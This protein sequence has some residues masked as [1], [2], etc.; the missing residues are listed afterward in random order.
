MKR[1]SRSQYL[2]HIVTAL[3][4]L[5]LYIPIIVL[6]IFSFNKAATSYQWEGFSTTWYKQLFESTEVWHALSNSLIVAS[7][8]VFLSVLMAVA[9]VYY[10]SHLSRWFF[11]FY[12]S[13]A[14]P[15]V[16]LAVGL[17]GF[18]SIFSFS[19]GFVTL[20]TGHTLLGLGYAI[21]IIQARFAELE[22]HL[23]EASLDLGATRAQT[24]FRIMLPLLS[25]AIL[26][27]A[28]LVFVLSF[29]DF[30]I[31]FFTAG[32]SSETLPLY[33][34]SVVRAGESLMINA[35]ST[36]L[37]CFGSICMLLIALLRGQKDSFLAHKE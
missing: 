16:V 10:G 18:F 35:L 33:I 15:E 26:A 22:R 4:Y 32:A 37:L 20:I 28:L 1:S 29:D 24:F 21:P 13:L 7:V 2:L 25:P 5:F 31:A 11:L 19:L 23:S 17:L 3:L 30:V 12:G 27:A 8:S 9:L 14:I 36:L 6:I 34:F